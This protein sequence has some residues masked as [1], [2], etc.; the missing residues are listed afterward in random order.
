MVEMWFER[1]V[2]FFNTV[3]HGITRT[4]RDEMVTPFGRYY[5]VLRVRSLLHSI[6]RAR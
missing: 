1:E 2:C 3:L 5:T 6:T 4:V